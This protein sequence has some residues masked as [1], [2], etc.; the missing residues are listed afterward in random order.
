MLYAAGLV[1]GGMGGM[2]GMGDKD[3]G[4]GEKAYGCRAGTEMGDARYRSRGGA[5]GDVYGEAVGGYGDCVYMM[6]G[7]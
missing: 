3:C 2:G 6:A 4:G 7:S 1:P 5:G